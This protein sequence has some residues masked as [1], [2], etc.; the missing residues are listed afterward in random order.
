MPEPADTVSY[1]RKIAIDCFNLL[2]N[3]CLQV[4]S[5]RVKNEISRRDR[6]RG[7][8]TLRWFTPD[9]AVVV[10]AL[11]NLIVPS[12]DE[13]PGLDEV[14][15]LG[16]SA[17]VV[18]DNL[19]RTS[20]NRQHLYSRGLLSFDTWA[21][22]QSGSKFAEMP[23]ENQIMLLRAA[24]QIH[25]GWIASGSVALKV[26]RRLRAI[27]QVKNGSL[28]AAQLYP[29]IRDDCLQVFYTSRVSW[30]WLDYDGPPMDKGHPSVFERR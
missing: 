21:I 24:Q 18:L 22:N 26:W 19:V 3:A 7:R 5:R 10:E 28:F 1:L 30:I 29:Q 13:T 11:A 15:V 23:K 4:A 8:S 9:E 17:I 20:S 2:Q 12:D 16:P 6:E 14:D 25:D 27:A